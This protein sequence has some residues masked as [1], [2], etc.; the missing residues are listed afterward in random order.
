MQRTEPDT[1]NPFE[2]YAGAVPHFLSR[3]EVSEWIRRLRDDATADEPI[4]GSQP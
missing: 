1:T 3:T 4:T 2:K